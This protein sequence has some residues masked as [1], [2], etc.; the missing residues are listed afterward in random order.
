VFRSRLNVADYGFPA[1]T[2]RI[3]IFTEFYGAPQ[4][5]RIVRPIRVE[6]DE[7]IRIRRVSP[8]LV[9][10]ILGWGELAIATGRARMSDADLAEGK[11]AAPIVK[12]FT[13]ILGRSFLIESVEFGSI[14]KELAS[15]PEGAARSASAPPHRDL[16][17]LRSR[18]AEIPSP[19]S[20]EQAS[21][22]PDRK[23]TRVAKAD[24]HTR[25][26]VALDILAE[27]SGNITTAK[28]FQ[29]D[30]TYVLLASVTCSAAVTVEGGA[31][32][33]AYPGT[34]LKLSNTLTCKA[35]S[36]RPAIF[37]SKDDD[38]I[39]DPAPGSTGTVSGFYGNPAP[40]LMG[41]RITSMMPMVM[42]SPIRQ[43]PPPL[44]SLA[45]SQRPPTTQFRSS[46]IAPTINWTSWSTM[47]I[48]W[49]SR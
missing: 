36:Y 9:D 20:A 13:N 26:G 19:R 34:Y 21:A 32:F 4:P 39:G 43:I 15:L 49:A 40:M 6:P 42:A 44:L 14:D 45:H 1:E 25:P 10:E 8:D 17:K 7:K 29:G 46:R 23:T 12:T 38:T 2:T 18:Y 41:L 27:I 24:I 37:T 30:T 3:Q 35:S 16:R 22:A 47:L 31:V 11:A 48:S 28:I 5:D 33:K